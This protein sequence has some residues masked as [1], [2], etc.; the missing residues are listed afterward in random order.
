LLWQRVQAGVGGGHLEVQIW[1]GQAHVFSIFG[2]VPEARLAMLEVARFIAQLD[3]GWFDG[4]TEGDAGD[5]PLAA[6]A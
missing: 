5:K 1:P 2:L 4:N 3:H 6:E